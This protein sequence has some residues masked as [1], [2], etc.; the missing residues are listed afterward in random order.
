M[1][2]KWHVSKVSQSF[3]GSGRGMFE[4]SLVYKQISGQP[5]LQSETFF[6]QSRQGEVVHY[7]NSSIWAIE[8]GEPQDQSVCTSSRLHSKTLSPDSTKKMLHLTIFDFLKNTYF[9]VMCML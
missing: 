6:P 1:H 9:Y 3:K 2:Q 4:V 7:F 8:A 5:E